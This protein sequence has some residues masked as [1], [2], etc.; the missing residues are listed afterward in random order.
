M[1]RT[2]IIAALVGVLAG[3]SALAD[4][5]SDQIQTLKKQI[6]RFSRSRND[7][8]HFADCSLR[9]AASLLSRCSLYIGNDSGFSHLAAAAGC[10]VLVLFGPTNPVVWGPLGNVEIVSAGFPAP[11]DRIAVDT[12]FRKAVSLL[13]PGTDHRR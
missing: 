2:F 4:E 12:V 1:K 9:T 11:I 3:A 6:D 5:T 13:A 8:T 10:R 7:V